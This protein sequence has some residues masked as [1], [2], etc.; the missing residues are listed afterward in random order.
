MDELDADETG[1]NIL[2]QR[3]AAVESAIRT[4][5]TEYANLK[6]DLVKTIK[7]A[8]AAEFVKLA[9]AINLPTSSQMRQSTVSMK[10]LNTSRPSAAD[11]NEDEEEE[12]DGLDLWQP[13]K[14]ADEFIAFE[15]KIKSDPKIVE[16]YV[17]LIY[18]CFIC[19]VLFVSNYFAFN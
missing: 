16:Q 12:N 18:C 15:N 4:Q 3:I 17:S 8:V 5:S 13:I 1:E 6:E 10:L 14:T 7:E 9:L 2:V 11:G 19:N